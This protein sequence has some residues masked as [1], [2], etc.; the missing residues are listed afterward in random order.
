MARQAAIH[1]RRARQQQQRQTNWL[2]IGGIVGTL[3][4]VLG[5]FALAWRPAE[6]GFPNLADYCD[7]NSGNCLSSGPASA[8]V[9]VVEIS[10][11]GC[12][13][14]R[15]FNLDTASLLKAEYVE[16]GRI[17][18]L[19]VPFS[20]SAQTAPAAEAALCAA[21]QDAFEAFH[22][23]M[24]EVQDD[25][26]ALTPTAFL[27]AAAN[28]GLNTETFNTCL[29]SNRYQGIV[30]DNN[31]AATRAGVKATPSFFINGVLLEGNYPLETFRQR[32]ESLLD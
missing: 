26:T 28:L 9:T 24:F 19:T 18:W 13:H 16:T 31:R 5:L 10:D 6:T 8:P 3:L 4:V 17:R 2:L 23:R 20:L 11:Y 7:E 21:E 29:T 22:Q 1:R 12:G 14:C 30:A 25:P 27:A 15:D 32:L